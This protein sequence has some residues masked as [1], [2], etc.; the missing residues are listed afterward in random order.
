MRNL[1]TSI[2]AGSEYQEEASRHPDELSAANS[3]LGGRHDLPVPAH[4]EPPFGRAECGFQAGKMNSVLG[5]LVNLKIGL[6]LSDC[7]GLQ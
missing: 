1:V 4:F 5:W 7:L 3:Y 6:D 2:Q